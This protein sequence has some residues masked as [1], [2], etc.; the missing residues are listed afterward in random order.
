VP[1]QALL[2]LAKRQIADKP[3]GLWILESD[4]GFDYEWFGEGNVVRSSSEEGKNAIHRAM[5]SGQLKI[6]LTFLCE[7]PETGQHYFIREGCNANS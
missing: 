2:E 1:D 4:L 3:A 7:D 5:A 6:G